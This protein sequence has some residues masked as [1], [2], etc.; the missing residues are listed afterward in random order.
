MYHVTVTNQRRN[1]AETLCEGLGEAVLFGRTQG[2][3]GNRI[4]V[5]EALQEATGDILHL[6]E[7][8][9]VTLDE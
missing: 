2:Q 7:V 5:Y 9:S 4:T 3:K 1:I 8:L 6:D